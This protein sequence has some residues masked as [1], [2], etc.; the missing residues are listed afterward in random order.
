MEEENP[1]ETRE[2]LEELHEHAEGAGAKGHSWVRFLSISTAIIA[3][4]AAVSTL[5]S[6]HYANE[7]LLLKNDA[8]FSQTKASD[9]WSYYQAKGIKHDLAAGFLAQRPDP[10]GEARVAKLE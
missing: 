1:L 4:L 2:Q 6:G 9:Q 5:M 8:I 7:A 10:Q 3:V